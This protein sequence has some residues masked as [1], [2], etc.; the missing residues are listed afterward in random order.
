MRF[1]GNE[2]STV[3]HVPASHRRLIRRRI[4]AQ[5]SAPS[6]PREMKKKKPKKPSPS[7][8]NPTGSSKKSPSPPTKSPS[9]PTNSPSPPDPPQIMAT[10]NDS[11]NQANKEVSDAQSDSPVDVEAQLQVNLPFS[12]LSVQP[13]EAHQLRQ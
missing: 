5:L 9:P 1:L 10:N 7:K 6:P 3:T 8:A 13:I 11:V 4:L 2:S 12:D